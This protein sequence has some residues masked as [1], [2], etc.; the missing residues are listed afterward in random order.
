M[1]FDDL[2]SFETYNSKMDD[3]GN[4]RK[5]YDAIAGDF[6]DIGTWE[7][8]DA[9]MSQ[10]T[11]VPKMPFAE[12]SNM[13][14]DML[15]GNGDTTDDGTHNTG[16]QSEGEHWQ[17]YG[18]DLASI[19]SRIDR[20]ISNFNASASENIARTGRLAETYSPEGCAQASAAKRQAQ[21]MGAPTS[22]TGLAG[23][24]IQENTEDEANTGKSE[25]RPLMSTRSP[26]VHG[27]KI[28]DG[29]AQTEWMLP[30]GR[31][32]S[33][34]MDAHKAESG[35][36]DVR[37]MRVFLSRMKN[38]G[39]D[40]SD[41][42]DIE[43]Q[44]ILDENDRKAV[45]LPGKIREM[46]QRISEI[47][48]RI[49]ERNQELSQQ[50]EEIRRK[51]KGF[52]SGY[53]AAIGSSQTNDSDEEL[54]ALR[55]SLQQAHKSLQQLTN[56]QDQ[57]DNG[58]GFW[59]GFGR[60]TWQTISDVR[61][62]D[63]GY[64]DLV[65]TRT[66]LDI[67][68]KANKGE[69][70]TDNEQ[71]AM[72]DIAVNQAVISQFGDL[73]KGY[74]WGNMAGISL[75][76][77]KDFWLTG[78]YSKLPGIATKGLTKGAKGLGVS[79]ANDV[80]KRA[81]RRGIL[82][83]VRKEGM[84]GVGAL[85][86]E[87]SVPWMVK[88]LG[89]TADDLLMRAPLM[90]VTVQGM[91]TASEII[92]HKLGNVEYNPETS[93]YK[94]ANGETWSN[95]IWQAGADK[96]IENFSEMWGGHLPGMADI[97][98]AFGARNLTAA[99]LR[100]TREGANTVISKAANFLKRTGVNGYF[101][102]VGEEY[103]G[104]LWRTVLGLDSAHDENGMN[105]FKSGQFHEDIWGGMAL[106]IGLTGGGAV[107]I[108]S[109]MKYGGKA[110]DYYMIRNTVNRTDRMAG[111]ALG[112]EAWDPM[113][114]VIDATDNANIG[115]LAQQ[116]WNDPSMTEQQ[117]AAVLD[118]MEASM[119]MRGHNLREFVTQE[120]E[121]E[122][123][124][125]NAMADAY[126][127]GMNI[128]SAED[129]NRTRM[130]LDYQSDHLRNTLKLADNAD[131]NSVLAA[132]YGTD[133]INAIVT[134]LYNDN[135][136]SEA[137]RSAITEYLIAANRYNGMM[138]AVHDA[139]E[140]EVAGQTAFV[141]N[142]SDRSDPENPVMRPAMLKNDNEQVFI[143]SGNAVMMPDGSMVDRANSD[144][145]IIIRDLNGNVRSIDAA[146][147]QTVADPENAADAKARIAEQIRTGRMAEY[148]A[149]INGKGESITGTNQPGSEP[150][151]VGRAV[152]KIDDRPV[153][154]ISGRVV[155]MDGSTMIDSEHSD[156]SIVIRDLA[157]SQIE[158]VSPEAILSYEEYAPAEQP[159]VN[160]QADDAATGQP[161]YTSGQIKIRNSDGSESRGVLTGYVDE[162]GKHEYY[163]EGDLQRLH[164]ATE[165]ELDNI[166]SDYQPDAP[167]QPEL[168]VNTPADNGIVPENT[169]TVPNPV[170]NAAPV[171]ENEPEAV[172]TAEPTPLQRIPRDEKGEPI[173]EQAETPELAWDALVEYSEGD[174]ATAKVIAD[175]MAEEKKKVF[176]KAQKLKLKGKTPAEML[177]SR[178]ANAAELAKAQSEYEH[179]QNMANVEQ[180][181]RDAIRS[182]QEAEDRRLAEQQAQAEEAERVAREEA[183]RIEREA[184]E[185]I[186]EWHMDTPENARARGARRFFGE[187]FT[188]QG[189][190]HH[191]PGKEVMV[192]FSQKD[193]PKGRIAVIE[194]S[195]LQPSHVQGNRN[196]MFFIDEAQ[197]KNR[198][199]AVSTYAA[200]Q[201]AEDIRPEEITGSATAYTGAPTVNLRGEVIQGNNRSDALRYLWEN[202]LAGQQE[203][204]KQYIIDNAVQFGLDTDAVNA[205]QQPVLVNMLDINDAEAIRLGQMTAQDT[206]SGGIER[207]KPRN[208]AQK[209]GDD[210][211]QFANMLLRTDDED[212]TFGQLVDRNGSDV[213][214][215]MSRV[216]AISNTQYQSAFDSKGNLTAEA[217]ND[218]RK[219]LYQA[220]FK[221]G[222]QQLEE[223]FDR[224]PAKAQ[225]AILSTAFRDM[226]SPIAG[227]MLPEIQASIIAY[228]LLMADH[229]F[230]AARK[231]VD[232]LRAVDAF[233]HV[234][235]LDDRFEQYM[236]TDNFSNFALHLAAMYKTS[237]MS[238]TTI[239]SIFNQMYDLAQG[240]KA[241]T[242]FEDADTT[243]YPL[244]DVIKKVL[245]IDYKPAK[246]G[247][248]NVA[249]GGADVALRDRI[250][251]EGQL[252]G[253]EPPASGKQTPAGTEPSDRGAGAADDSTAAGGN[254]DVQGG[255]TDDA[256]NGELA[257]RVT[258]SVGPFGEIYTQFKGK[259][260]EAVTFLLAKRSGE[261]IG[262]LYHKD[263]GDIDLVWG[264]EGTAHSD[265]YGLAKLAK[266]H[267]EVLFN[268]QE[269]LNDMVVTKRSTN[270]VQLESD[271]YQAA[272]RL[273]WDD[274]KK[275][276]LLTMFEKK[277]SVP[278]NTTDT[279]ETLSSNGNDTATPENTVISSDVYSV[280]AVGEGINTD[281]S[282]VDSGQTE[283]VT[284]P[285]GNSSQTSYRKD[286]K[287]LSSR[288]IQKEESSAQ[289]VEDKDISSI[290]STVEAASAEV[291]TE[292]TPAQ[293]E[294]GNYKK[295]HVIIGDF[296]I[297]IE[298]P[299]GSIRKGVDAD[300]KEWQTTMANAY[301]Y[302]KG[303]ESVDGDHIDI[304]LH[305]DMDEWDGR[306]VY[307]VDQTRPD[308]SFDE[309]K[310][311]LGFNDK[312]NAMSAYLANYDA[313][314]AEKHP[315][316]RISEVNIEDFNKW[317]QSSHRKTKPFADYSTI[318]KI[319]DNAPSK[320]QKNDGFTIEARKD[321]RDNS[322]LFAVKFEERVSR[323]EFKGQKVIA[324]KY[325]GYWSNF[326]KKGFLFKSE[327]DAKAFAAEVLN[328]SEEEIADDAPLS[329]TDMRPTDVTEKQP[330]TEQTIKEVTEDGATLTG[331]SES[332]NE[333]PINPSGNRLVT[334]EQYADYLARFKK[335]LGGQLNMGVD[336]EILQLG[337][338]MA[339]YHIEK[340]ARKFAAYVRAMVHDLGEMSDKVPYQYLKGF[341]K[342]AH[343]MLEYEMPEIAEEMDSDEIVNNTD[344]ATIV[345]GHTDAIASAKM[346]TAEQQ[347]EKERVE[348]ERKL[349]EMRIQKDGKKTHAIIGN[350]DYVDLARRKTKDQEYHK[351]NE[352]AVISQ[353]E[354]AI[355]NLNVYDNV[356]NTNADSGGDSDNADQP[357]LAGISLAETDRRGKR[358]TGGGLAKPMDRGD[359]GSA[360]SKTSSDRTNSQGN[361]GAVAGERSNKGISEE[362]SS[363]D[364]IP[365]G[366]RDSGGRSG[367]RSDRSDGRKD[368]RGSGSKNTVD[369]TDRGIASRH[370]NDSKA[371]SSVNNPLQQAIDDLIASLADRAKAIASGARVGYEVLRKGI[372]KLSVWSKSMRQYLGVPLQQSGISNTE[373]D[374][375]IS[376]MWECDYTANGTTR[377]IREWAALMSQ[378][379]LRSKVRLSFDE[380]RAAQQAAEPIEVK[381]TDAENIRETLPFLLPQQQ[382]DVRLA[383]VQFFDQSHADEMHGN[384]KGYMFTNGTGTGK[385]Y[386][387]LGIVKRF[388]KQG[389]GRILILTPSQTKVRDWIKDGNNL[390]L[391]IRDLDSWAKEHGTTATTEKGEGVVITTYANF[392]Q[393]KALEEDCFDLIVY[394]ESHRLLENKKGTATEGVSAHYM[395]S[396]KNEDYAFTRLRNV[397]SVYKDMLN[398]IED[399]NKLFNEVVRKAKATTGIDNMFT[400]VT[401]RHIPPIGREEWSPA[402]EA[403]FPELAALRNKA[404]ELESR[405]N[406]NERPKVEKQAKEDSARTKVVFL[407]A[408]P[409]NTRENIDYAEGYIFSYPKDND[410]GYK[411]PHGRNRFFLDHFGAGYKWRYHRLE[412]SI[413]NAQA[414]AQQEVEFSDWLQRDLQT[415]SGRVIDSEYDYSRDFPTVTGEYAVRFNE[416]TS[417][418][419]RN[420]YTSDAYHETIGNYNYGS[421]LFESMKV[422]QIIPRIRKHLEA[423]RK[424]VIF[425]RRV[426]TKEPLGLPFTTLF[427][428][429]TE[430]AKSKKDPHKVR[431]A[432]DELHRLR[433]RYKDLFE[434]EKSLD[435]R[436][437][438]Q[439][440]AD[441]F[442]K[443]NISFFS[444]KESNKDK[445]RAVEDFN[446]DDSNKNIIVVQEASGKEGIS[447]HDISGKHQRVI[448]TLALPQ[449]PITALQ[450]E[451]RIFRIGNRSNAIFEYPLLGLDSEM[452]LFGQTFNAQVGTTEN[453][454]LGSKARNL[455]ESFA[456]GIE[457]NSG[458]VD[459]ERQGIGGKEMDA[460]MDIGNTSPFERAVLDYYTNHKISLS[461]VNREGKDYY[462]TPEPLGYMM[463]VWS[464]IS[465]GES[466]LEPSAGHGAIARYV[467]AANT[468]T[469][470]EPSAS[471]F[472]RLQIKAGGIGRKFESCMFED[473]NI[474]NKHD[475]VLMNPP[476]GT[477]GKLAVEHVTKAFKHLE[478]GGRIVAIIPRGST[479]RKFEQWYN[480]EKNAVL[481]GEIKLPDIT[482]ERAGT[483]VRCR[484]VVI[485]KVSNKALATQ[486][487]SNAQQIDLSSRNY[488]KIEDF[489]NDIS[490]IQMP[491][492][493]IDT[494]AKLRK[495]CLPV[496]RSLRDMK[497]IK[498]VEVG[499]D[500][501]KVSGRGLWERIDWGGI[502][503]SGIEALMR[504]KF[505]NF[506]TW[507]AN[508][509]QRGNLNEAAVYNELK[510]LCARLAGKTYEDLSRNIDA[511][512]SE[513]VISYNS[514][515]NTIFAD[516]YETQD[517]KTINYTSE[518]PEAYGVPKAKD[519]SDDSR[520]GAADLQRQGNSGLEAHNNRLNTEL[521][522]FS[523]VERVFKETGAFNF[524]SGERIESADDVAFIFSSLEDA[525]KEHAFMVLVKDGD[526][527][528]VELGMGTFT[529][530]LVDIPTASLA[531]NRIK[532]D[533]VYFVHNHPSGNLKCSPEDM[534]VLETMER[535]TEMPVHGVIINLK[536]GKYGTFGKGE[537]SSV[538]YK[539]IPETESPLKVHTLDKQIFA[540]DYD[541]MSQP[542]VRDSEDVAKFLNSHR[543]GDRA[544]VSFLIISR[545]GRIVG[546]IHTPFI[547]ITNDVTDK[548]RYISDRITQFGGESAI[549]YGDFAINYNDS[550]AFQRLKQSLQQV[551]GTNLLDVVNV[552]G[553]YTRSARDEGML[554]EPGNEYG[555]SD[556]SIRYG[557]GDSKESSKD[558]NSR[559]HSVAFFNEE[560]ERYING[561]M[562]A[563]EMLHLGMPNGAM[564]LFLPDMPIVMR[565]RIL[566]KASFK[567]HNIELSALTDMP[568]HLSEP[569]F[570][571]HRSVNTIGVLTEMTDRDGKNVCVAIELQAKIQ[572]GHEIIEVND[573]R[574]VHGRR[575]ENIIRPILENGNLQW[576][577]R[578]KGLEW[579]SSASQQV[580]QEIAT[581]DLE[582][583]AKIVDSFE[584][585]TLSEAESLSGDVETMRGQGEELAARLHT[586]VRFINNVEEITDNDVAMQRKKCSAK[587]W[588]DTIT[589]DVVMVLPNCE[590]VADVEATL[591]HEVVAHK[592]LRELI[593]DKN[594]DDFC[595]EVY[596]HLKHDLKQSV[597]TDATRRFINDPAKGYEYHRHVAVD[598]LF[599]R[600]SEKGFE[601]FTETERGIWTKLKA[602]VLE[603]INKF[604]GSL[605]LPKWVKLGDNELRY[606]LWRSHER[607]S[608]GKG[609]YVD[610]ARDAAK[611]EDLKIG[612]DV[613]MRDEV[614]RHKKMSNTNEAGLNPITVPVDAEHIAKVAQK[615]ENAKSQLRM[616]AEK[617]AN[618]VNDR[619]F[620]ADLKR[621]LGMDGRVGSSGYKS[622]ELYDGHRVTV[623]ISNHNANSEYAREPMVS[624]VVKRRQTP[625]TFRA[626]IGQEVH[627]YVYFRDEL[628]K[629]PAGTLSAI[630]DS[631]SEMLDTGKYVDK[632]GLAKEN[633]SDLRFRSG[634]TD[635]IWN[636]H[637]VGLEERITNAALRLS[638]NQSADLTL[639]NDAKLAVTNNLQSLL[640][641]MR[642]RRGTTRSFVGADRKIKTGVVGAM[643]A[644]AMY[645]R[646]TVKRVADLA[647][648]LMQH[649]Y[650]SGITSGEMQRLLSAVKNATAKNDTAEYVQKILDIMVDNQLRNGE[651]TLRQLLAVRGSK[652]DA[653]GVEVQ[654]ALDVDGQ[655]TIEVV[656]KAMSLKEDD[657]N[658]RIAEAL[659]LMSDTDQT[660]AD[661]A[662]I[663][664]TGLNIALDYVQNIAGSKADEEALRDSIKT[665]KED[666]DAGRMTYDAYK[667]Y[668]ETTEDAIRKNKIERS[669]AYFNLVGRLSDSLRGSIENA[670][671][672]RESE[673]ARVN[674]IH[675]LANSDMEGKQLRGDR[676]DTRLQKLANWWPVRF[677]LE[678]MSTFDQMLKLFG[679]KNPN[680]EGYLHDYFMR[681]WV[682]AVDKEQLMKEHYH[683]LMDAK[684]AE[685]FGKRKVWR[686]GKTKAV[687]YS[688]IDL[689]DY[690]DALPK[691]K[692]AYHD[693]AEMREF[694]VSQGELLYLY[695]VEKMPM[696]R[697]T[698]RKMGITEAAMQNITNTLDS[699]LKAYADWTQEELL[700]QMGKDMDDVHVR[701]FG[702]HMENI[703]NYFPFVRDKNTLKR[704][705][706]NGRE[707]QPNDR[708][709]V[710]TGAIKKRVASVAK[711]DMRNCNF[712]D[713]LAR[714]IDNDGCH[715]SAFA[716]MNRDIGTLISYNRLKQQ[717]LAMSSVYG[718]G[719]KLWTRF[720]QCA[721]IATDAYE[722]K[723]SKFDELMVQGAKGVT[724]GKISFRLF[725]ALKQTLSL[726]AFFGEITP[727]YIIKDLTTL[728]V[729]ACKWSW[730][731]LPNYR[732]RILSR[733]AGDYRLRE[734]EYDNKIMKASS[735]GMLPNIG[736]DAWT[737]AVGAHSVYQTKKAKYLSWGMNEEQAE[738]RAIQDAEL[739]FN[740]SQQSSEGPFM[741]PIQVDHTFYATSA[742]LLRNSSTSYTREAHTSARNLMRIISGE[743]NEDFVAKQILRT[744]GTK[745]YGQRF[746]EELTK[747][748]AGSLPA[749]HIYSLGMPGGILQ[750]AGFPDM[751]IEMAASRLAAKANQGNHIFPIGAVK[752][753]VEALNK[754]LAVFKYGN[755]AMNVIVGLSY[756]GKQFLVGVH[757]NQQRNGIE[758]SSVRGLFPKD[759][760][761]WLN[762]ISQ[763][764]ATYLNHKKIQALIDKQRINLADV[765]YL[766]LEDVTKIMENF[767]NPIIPEQK[768]DMSWSEAEWRH[769]RKLAK[770]EIRSATIK[771]TVNLAMFGWVLPW[772]WRIGSIA[773]FLFLSS[774]DD[775]KEKQIVDVLKQS[776]FAPIEGLAYG[777]VMS[778]A[779][780]ILTGNNE[781]RLSSLG[782]TNPILSDIVLAMRKADKDKMAAANDIFNILL[783][784]A[785]GVNPQTFTDW[786]SAILDYSGA[787]PEMR[788]ECSML[789]ARLLSCPQS[790]L[791]KIHF[792][793]LDLNG[794]EASKLT[795]AQLAKRY[796][797]YKVKRGT[798]FA[799]WS[800][801]D[802]ERT[803]KYEGKAKD[804]MEK[805]LESQGDTKI[806][807]AYANFE[808]RYNTVKKKNSVD[809]LM[810]TD[811]AA[812]AQAHVELLQD[813]DFS[814]YKLFDHYDRQLAHI[815]KMW[816]SAKTPEEAALISSTIPAYR[817]GMVKVLQAETAEVQ[818]SAMAELSTL[819]NEFYAKYQAM[820]PT[821]MQSNR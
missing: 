216:G 546:N 613:I 820:Q 309:H 504:E 551:G 549:L 382:E 450:I 481:T 24:G 434:W 32:S 74:R 314:W 677:A 811:Y 261:A 727:K 671:A 817:A 362:T 706:E 422:S 47:E 753:L 183:A 520:T 438:R 3:E 215:W 101:G 609:D 417:E 574:S 545:A 332:D 232:V 737:I 243:Q 695:A 77:I 119:V 229:D 41:K 502:D 165:S 770:K 155:M 117:K 384:G 803:D 771:N 244:A 304:F 255:N 297:T 751:P 808:A 816:L 79:F 457:E 506:S 533:Q 602:K 559:Y 685:I 212:A 73:G 126:I 168:S 94:F 721:A 643:K 453:L 399:Y 36:R 247:N 97:A 214:K 283:G 301:G 103:Y 539:R 266:F 633:H 742:M 307:V 564:K 663:E 692:V 486:A 513:P 276:W 550:G 228:D 614:S 240:K 296:D 361:S 291:N 592:G 139:I 145:F 580:Q 409:F 26:E 14:K 563:N 777:D 679:N 123:T 484:V 220:V 440:L 655:Y 437:P 625:N 85:L 497:I 192:K 548:A 725:T 90:A 63:F 375:W 650:L 387:G 246:N 68:S 336:P 552:E 439:Q 568:K 476:F 316:L 8:F 370:V 718:S 258:P 225:R 540:R 471:L 554:Y 515:E 498:N 462:P 447:L 378:N 812:A 45:T 426:E 284:A 1:E 179:W 242:L 163:V 765:D 733:T 273:T 804:I 128:G 705:I 508:A 326:G 717:V 786:A 271:K 682:D 294:A 523:V 797:E 328:K 543:M 318:S 661:K 263:I 363:M 495:R 645:D 610:M 98:K 346:V 590:N 11:L 102:E 444:G 352:K 339:V 626:A 80:A 489:F 25:G 334:D 764:K 709:S 575:E 61:T 536:T 516:T 39:L 191:V 180:Y 696:G 761:E 132:M 634:E 253:N 129:R 620:L 494:A 503:K 60:A 373:I 76:F 748:V 394:D 391:E 780:G 773:P 762:W 734:T 768:S 222:S 432:L 445:H 760:A 452:V 383:E 337:A 715:W 809:E 178:K 358:D 194:A 268:L 477:A 288:Q 16:T 681:S 774:D 558:D 161:G 5:L 406:E 792:E 290:Q 805:R 802:E 505:A 393:N 781:K 158:T 694:E 219:V 658:D 82:Q 202:N 257:E 134:E 234:I 71:R 230:A 9:K 723:R 186:P 245:N 28:V 171:V 224:L 81:A 619:G 93:Q 531:Y 333:K 787:D 651:A 7:E 767:E 693:G 641:T 691:A 509:E 12:V 724:M 427:A 327:A 769:T 707:S 154:V 512:A 712:F 146:D 4:R 608:S 772:L 357:Q 779:L 720:K 451:G 209:L 164:Y 514:T 456:R 15:N 731:N 58:N 518:N 754:P 425:H 67:T 306:K 141:D 213:I 442:G 708:V 537:L 472:S 115:E 722:P 553:N 745:T 153:E 292:P 423:G 349:K 413:E 556:D 411:T 233:K 526:P 113:R 160:T 465:D 755:N 470:I 355:S 259:P 813:P 392:R 368:R 788:N 386:T 618:A 140:T 412:N 789:V 319:T 21:L 83:F 818:Q 201:I 407:S 660:I 137:D 403:K 582:A 410:G 766:D 535:M 680:G 461:R 367:N 96:V 500:F 87:Q 798:P 672:F 507:E 585:P 418:L 395:V 340:G 642:N 365:A 106:S 143:I 510:H 17:P 62:W 449:S 638:A 312:D 381:V 676:R 739:A 501:I 388:V 782:R 227:R 23:N 778:D 810:K 617:Y 34:I 70:L 443:E 167:V 37:L 605:K 75:S 557:L 517:G 377:R 698:N 569:I 668:V 487:A 341:Y 436:M 122:L 279:V 359:S 577:D 78:G 433:R 174:T 702:A 105:L 252:R 735:Y 482:F 285:A 716:E 657:I 635:D 114:L 151:P 277:N 646:S 342:N 325:D 286:N 649:G 416:A 130:S 329:L 208:V 172:S 544:K 157:T 264:K 441:A 521:G 69:K 579:L 615:L 479:D 262:A 335:K 547:D 511:T 496:A 538:G 555:A 221:G 99:V 573:I 606:M 125:R 561:D 350:E 331:K 670:K 29:K 205:M 729:T 44:R 485:D 567:K 269:V 322:D 738:R 644:Q 135:T 338:M 43:K 747:Q 22:V 398:A 311:M 647:R 612:T 293:A 348:A 589:G 198:A 776:I 282:E 488:T 66:M 699:K 652:V 400:L 396:N 700:P 420:K 598:E 791:D 404:K 819:M 664:Y 298:N 689:Y 490:N 203:A 683:K 408:T 628:L 459:I 572:N 148:Q 640:H 330:S 351:S 187:L 397:N 116:V 136:A 601:D 666:R 458:D 175:S 474:V 636:D 142:Y 231:M 687:A 323:D 578:E 656:N 182:Q 299:A 415:M 775:E 414:L 188:R 267:P 10:R 428:C 499:E 104:Q 310:V 674:N 570:V 401:N 473:Y 260:Q 72:E 48:R 637:S 280:P 571:F 596:K 815:S 237:D 757:F 107:A 492:R 149:Q 347:A 588:Y 419:L 430:K 741:A 315:G 402:T 308:S 662:A 591:F 138:Q 364:R 210:M 95:A 51:D 719:E 732:K 86:K 710:Q 190:V 249:N 256:A 522:E 313:T 303:T 631:I 464:G 211:R 629:A 120:S 528:V 821:L 64:S 448:I 659:N 42:E 604:L 478:E 752:G 2:G 272:V 321:T 583:V 736:V 92:G 27:V 686:N 353:K 53:G 759:N 667:Q 460:N 374:E 701:M 281:T 405:F 480:S 597:D 343:S 369:D 159:V 800:W 376:E 603:A 678:P 302:I 40:P 600:L 30:D 177:A 542:M 611:R 784:S 196:P 763:G 623:R 599:G 711:W 162:E 91:S 690:A 621:G 289:I 133:D 785:V 131:V 147:I 389:K 665:A 468:L 287:S 31:L 688:Y 576:V 749:G 703:E 675:H 795:P 463:N 446:A 455:R 239:A 466:V 65:D 57:I 56:A 669:E 108:S 801:D 532:P 50:W 18:S 185:G 783:G 799:L 697:A 111:T 581:K 217:K 366:D 181:R 435:L 475:I 207:I 586:P 236:P 13:A 379:E 380:K 144:S 54:R 317:I 524:T 584:N 560:L 793:E 200:Q 49:T 756:G 20:G 758:V 653:R 19:Q 100:N 324:K 265:G 189:P 493:T 152:M 726:P 565:Q 483:S 197:P 84:T 794:K 744:I 254:T 124:G 169:E 360:L 740:K 274:K 622:F 38:N 632:T 421:A 320:P 714:H 796:A 109:G 270:R 371:D 594:Y 807:E 385:T 251:Q 704:D 654:G 295:G 170:E 241:A 46:Q 648:I 238:Q 527:T 235:A 118:Y 684:V 184:L 728:G 529:A 562:E 176:E 195:Q 89:T 491:A 806:N 743:V 467:P 33:D 746:D 750:S 616:V 541:P 595:G 305:T 429:A 204:Y 193:L 673:K 630:A 624:I 150:R 121:K 627:E 52:F 713:V 431:E 639:R 275:T 112:Q 218:L 156:T 226:D 55:L 534:R 223:M 248:N 344:V 593:G 166:L 88:A 424:I 790:Q 390:N 6:D 127:E 454:A 372:Y 173:F 566:N 354:Q 35:A 278:D 250:S 814:L 469:A 519:G 587:G 730:E 300:G 59:R 345:N 356:R 607:L 199:E 110:V 530:S 525:A 206:E